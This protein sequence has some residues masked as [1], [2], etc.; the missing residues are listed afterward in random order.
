MI[1]QYDQLYNKKLCRAGT[2]IIDVHRDKSFQILVA[3]F[4][5]R[6]I[7]LLPDQVVAYSTD[8]PETV[9]ESH[10]SHGEM[11]GVISANDEAK[12]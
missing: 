5:E 7:D 1:E 10:I 6:A 8:H 12:N 3:N 4:G 11:F 9:T 2:G